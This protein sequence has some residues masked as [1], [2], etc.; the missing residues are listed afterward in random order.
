LIHFAVAI[1]YLDTRFIVA[2]YIKV[3]SRNIEYSWKIRQSLSIFRKSSVLSS[4]V[5]YACL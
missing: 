3:L 2:Y 1:K 4:C 5:F